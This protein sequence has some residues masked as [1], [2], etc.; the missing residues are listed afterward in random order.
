MFKLKDVELCVVWFKGLADNKPAL[1]Y[2]IKEESRLFIEFLVVKVVR[3]DRV[4]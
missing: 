1:L 4:F 2:H 3:I